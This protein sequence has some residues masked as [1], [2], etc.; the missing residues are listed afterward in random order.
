MQLRLRYTIYALNTSSSSS[1]LSNKIS[2]FDLLSSR[3]RLGYD[4]GDKNGQPVSDIKTRQSTSV[5]NEKWAVGI[6]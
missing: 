2:S 5:A 3:I 6:T 1:R 4:I